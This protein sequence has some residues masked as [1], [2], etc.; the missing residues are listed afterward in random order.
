MF[1]FTKQ[2][3]LQSNS[4]GPGWLW[5]IC[6]SSQDISGFSMLSSYLKAQEL[7]DATYRNYCHTE[8]SIF[9]LLHPVRIAGILRKVVFI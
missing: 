3:T 4:F 1:A 8:Q 9:A 7:E 2:S 6:R 5:N